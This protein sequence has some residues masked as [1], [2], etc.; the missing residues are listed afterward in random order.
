M[1]ILS[2][3]NVP[4]IPENITVHLG[5]PNAAAENLTMPFPDYIKN[6]ASGELDPTWPEAALK[7]NIYAIIS[8]TLN[9]I[10][11][12]AY[13]DQG[14]HFDVTNLSQYDQDFV[15]NR[16]VYENISRIVDENFDSYVIR[17]GTRMAIHMPY[18]DGLEA[19]CEGLSQQ[20]AVELAKQGKTPYQI[21]QYYFGEDIDIV[22]DIPID[23]NFESYPMYPLRVGSSGPEVGVIQHELNHISENYPTIPSI[24]NPDGNF[25]PETE[26]AVKAFQRAF[27][28]PGSGVVEKAT[29]Y[30]IKYIYNST[31][32]LGELFS[33]R[34]PGEFKRPSDAFWKEGDT[35]E[36]VNLI[37]YY[38]RVLACFYRLQPVIEITGVFGPETAQAAKSL[39]DFYGLP[40]NGVVD[41]D[42][43]GA[44][45][46]DYRKQFMNIPY[47]CFPVKPAYPGYFIYR[48]M[49]DRNV[50]LIQSYLRGIAERDPDIPMLPVTGVFD[51]AT[52]QAVLE[53]DRKYL[54]EAEGL[55]LIGPMTWSRIV[56]VYQNIA[57]S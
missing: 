22:K 10:Q 31:K 53:F 54:E 37:Q 43:L 25:T 24:Q 40:S 16:D 34:R 46:Q 41:A 30:K 18:C 8:S 15:P 50:R 32:G 5:D 12:G 6:V 3:P 45:Y 9:R 4:L 57:G 17:R 49:G 26:A 29:W 55:V 19:D 20:G 51:E 48:G 38:M 47:D 27:Y 33:A 21:L 35:G 36:W 11:T 52:E 44:L 23:A 28:L 2:R 39:G 7:A 56:S 13:R 14:Y 42:L 1:A